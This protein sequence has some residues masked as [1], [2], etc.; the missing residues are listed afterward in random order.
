MAGASEFSQEAAKRMH[1]GYVQSEQF[2]RRHPLESL[3]VCLGVGVV[4]GVVA[5]MLSR[6]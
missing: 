5:T 4:A 6:R 2:V 3:A 1:A